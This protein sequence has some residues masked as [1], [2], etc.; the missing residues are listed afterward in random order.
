MLTN[1]MEH[2]PN[3]SNIKVILL[4]DVTICYIFSNSLDKPASSSTQ[5]AVTFDQI[6][7]ES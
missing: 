5:W 1:I 4:W 6:V 2:Y 3:L 7:Q